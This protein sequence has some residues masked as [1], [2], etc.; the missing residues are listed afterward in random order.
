MV[1]M[2]SSHHAHGPSRHRRSEIR[3]HG[4][5][6]FGRGDEERSGDGEDGEKAE[7]REAEREPP[8]KE[9]VSGI[10]SGSPSGIGEE[11]CSR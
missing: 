3:G 7:E 5:T 10:E 11:S 1:N 9:L 2:A 4:S 6:G 8:R